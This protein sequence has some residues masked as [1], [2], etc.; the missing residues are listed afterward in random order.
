M[1]C[2]RQHGRSSP[3]RL[4]PNVKFRASGARKIVYSART[5]PLASRSHL[6]PPQLKCARERTRL[7]PASA[8]R[9]PHPSLVLTRAA[10]TVGARTYYVA[11][12][13]VADLFDLFTDGGVLDEQRVLGYSC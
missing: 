1:D 13:L 6:S 4:E 12:L 7:S 10:Y 11:D 2:L 8:T 5:P 3:L 9:P